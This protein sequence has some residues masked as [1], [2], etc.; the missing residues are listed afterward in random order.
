VSDA[1]GLCCLVLSIWYCLSLFDGAGESEWDLKGGFL[2]V[3][4]PVT[5]KGISPLFPDS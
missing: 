3:E 1:F 2:G 5:Q 4:S